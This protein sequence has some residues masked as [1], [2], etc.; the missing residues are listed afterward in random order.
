MINTTTTFT[1]DGVMM[2]DGAVIATNVRAQNNFDTGENLVTLT[3]VDGNGVYNK[4]TNSLEEYR[5]SMDK[6]RTINS[7]MPNS[8]NWYLFWNNQN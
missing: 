1:S 7:L 8:D 4:T 3:Y 5:M 2:S 6:S